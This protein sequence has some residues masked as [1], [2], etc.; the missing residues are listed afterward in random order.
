MTLSLPVL[1]L[2]VP[3]LTGLFPPVPGRWLAR[4]PSRSG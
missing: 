3:F 2:P 1:W 4:E